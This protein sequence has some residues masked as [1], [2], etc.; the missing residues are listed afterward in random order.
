MW[1]GALARPSSTCQLSNKQ[2]T[3]AT[4][5][6]L[7]LILAQLANWHPRIDVLEEK[8]QAQAWI[9]SLDRVRALII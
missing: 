1:A 4:P 9:D 5:E 6:N 8:K 3:T 2:M 7:E